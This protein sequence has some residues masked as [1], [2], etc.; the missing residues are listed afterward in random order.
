MRTTVRRSLATGGAPFEPALRRVRPTK[1][2]LIVLCD[3]SGSVAEFARFT[4]MLLDA[5]RS[6][7]AGLRTF[8]FVDGVAEMTAVLA[9]A[10]STLD[11]RLLVMLPGVV[12]D[13]GHSDY[14]RALRSFVEHF[15]DALSPA[16]TVLV[17][18]DARTNHRGAGLDSLEVIRSRC[19]RLYWFNPEPA[20][21]W[22]S[23]DSELHA[24]AELCDGVFEVRTLGQLAD[25]VAAIV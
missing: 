11:P 16:A 4:L 2:S 18:G 24:Y 14:E 9:R 15:D 20:H 5:L 1:P 13:D 23:T 7:M 17:T 12:A 25:A 21:E 3:I 19:R 6:E 10:Q 8:V 22:G